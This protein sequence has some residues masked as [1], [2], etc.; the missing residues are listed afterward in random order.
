MKR[1]F[2]FFVSFF[3]IVFFSPVICIGW[4]FATF[5]TK[6]NGFFVQKR[7][8]LNGS[9]FYVYKL[10]TMVS[11][12]ENTSSI[13]ALNESRITKTGQILRKYKIDE[14]PQLFN[15]L[16]GQMSLVGPRPDVPGYADCLIGDDRA[17]LSLR[18]GITGLATL[19]FKNEEEI[20]LKVE[21]P[22][23]FNDSV[24]FPLKTKI[25]LN[26]LQEHTM[27]LDIDLILITVIG[28]SLFGTI[29]TPFEQPDDCV[30]KLGIQNA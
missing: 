24:I 6:S 16:L 13:T 15:V 2:D 8:G 29:V 11:V 10:K 1:F 21:D 23:T 26:Y 3:G 25:N 28:R 7:V 27:K 18:P 9:I 30:S 20:L 22:K 12:S 17:I 14:L 5:S 4:L 19:H